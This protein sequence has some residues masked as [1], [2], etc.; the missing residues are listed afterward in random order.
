MEEEYQYEKE[1]GRVKNYVA[2]N[3]HEPKYK[4][5]AFTGVSLDIIIQL[6]DDGKL[7]ENEGELRIRRNKNLTNQ[8]REKLVSE[9]SVE[10][11]KDHL[12]KNES[13]LVRDLR[14]LKHGR[15]EKEDRS[16]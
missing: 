11:N 5:S 6:I 13:R 16:L 8:K 4:V 2:L 14:D 3:P 10:I 9:L 15:E 12:E 7:E 1:L